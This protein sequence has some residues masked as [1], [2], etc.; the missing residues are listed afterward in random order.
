MFDN[1]EKQGLID[2]SSLKP[3]EVLRLQTDD[4]DEVVLDTAQ[5]KYK[6]NVIYQRIAAVFD[7]LPPELKRSVE[8]EVEDAGEMT[9]GE[10]SDLLERMQ[11]CK[12]TWEKSNWKKDMKTLVLGIP[13][14]ELKALSEGID[15][16]MG[17]EPEVQ[18]FP[19][20]LKWMGMVEKVCYFTEAGALSSEP[21]GLAIVQKYLNRFLVE[22]FK[23]TAAALTDMTL[24]ER[25]APTRMAV[26]KV[27]EVLDGF[28]DITFLAIA[29]M[30]LVGRGVGLTEI[31]AV[32][33]V[34]AT[35]SAICDANL[36]KYPFDKVNGK[37]VKPKGWEGPG[38][39][40]KAALQHGLNRCDVGNLS[41]QL[42]LFTTR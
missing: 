3:T 13:Q 12:K 11:N 29:S 35:L 2:E 25:N 38:E 16:L 14:D 21:A 1:N 4:G 27:E 31:H 42:D 17:N 26:D 30:Y 20:H 18:A 5:I 23:E 7:T 32:K 41:A 8:R 40:T 37:I 39:E 15:K 33:L 19:T 22:E 28:G 36:R 24:V 34:N 9:A 6:P 10:I